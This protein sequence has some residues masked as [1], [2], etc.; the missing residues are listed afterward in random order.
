MPEE[1]P[2]QL[3]SPPLP[4]SLGFVFGFL[5]IFAL[6]GFRFGS[7][8]TQG[9]KNNPGLPVPFGPKMAWLALES[10]DADAVGTALGLREARAAT[11]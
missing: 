1:E 5:W 4:Y 6:N 10:T 8:F 2:R 11:W 7:E 3:T 9:S